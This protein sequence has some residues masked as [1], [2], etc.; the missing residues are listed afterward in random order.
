MDTHQD[1]SGAKIQPAFLWLFHLL[2]VFLLNT[3]LP[4]PLAFPALLIWPGR[5]LVI[6]GAALGLSALSGFWRARTTVNPHGSV[7]SIVTGGPY[8]F[9]RNPMYLGFAS[10]LIGFPLTFESYWGLILSPLFILLM[11]SLV[12]RHE[13][14]YLEKK[15]AEQYTSYKSRVRR[16]V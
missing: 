3:F 1:H 13:E 10:L 5:I 6:L 12:I 4:L 7:S 2:A 9:T 15:F 14:A 11:N 16:W 8:R